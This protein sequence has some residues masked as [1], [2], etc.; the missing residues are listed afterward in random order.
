MVIGFVVALSLLFAPVTMGDWSE[1]ASFSV[2]EID[3]S[4]AR[5][6]TPV[7]QFEDLSS[8]AQDAV[9]EAFGSSNGMHRVYGVEDWPSRF[10]YSD[11]ISPGSGLYV[12]V[13]EGEYYRLHSSGG[14]IVY[15]VF[16]LLELPFII[17]GGLLGWLSLQ[18][19]RGN[20]GPSLLL[21]VIVPGVV[22][23]LLGPEF[24]FPLVQPL[25]FTAL[26]TLAVITLAI[27]IRKQPLQ[28]RSNRPGTEAEQESF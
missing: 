16:W 8:D 15:P 21:L 18:T 22:F 20:R 9:R 4:E 2:E 5:E 23:H 25:V 26:G 13:Y 28:A 3:P 11:T 6:G 7:L 14:G 19:A 10:A 24:D 27:A 12:V 17:Y 1:H